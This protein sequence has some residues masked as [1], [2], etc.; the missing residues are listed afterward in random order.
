MNYATYFPAAQNPV[1]EGSA[2]INGGSVGLD[3][4]NIAV[5]TLGLTVGTQSG[6]ASPPTNDSIA[7]LAGIWGPDQTVQQ[8][9]RTINQPAGNVFE[10]IEC[11]LR[12]SISAHVAKGYEVLFSVNKLYAQIVRWNGALN[13]FEL[14][15][16]GIP[17]ALRTG[18]VLKAT[19]TGL[20]VPTIKGYINGVE[21]VSTTDDGSHGGAAYTS[22]NPGMGLFFQDDGSGGV[23]GDYGVTSFSATDGKGTKPKGFPWHQRMM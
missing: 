9:V 23:I 17:P 10:E 1:S 15:G 14:I 3:W 8:V 4:S 13:T 11:L 12:F 6:V 21:V 16:T 22:G 7:V 2:W 20:A 19:I 5:N 18:D